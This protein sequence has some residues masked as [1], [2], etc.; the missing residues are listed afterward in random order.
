MKSFIE[1]GPNFALE[2]EEMKRKYNIAPGERVLLVSPGSAVM[3]KEYRPEQLRIVI[4]QLCKQHPDVHILLLDDINPD[5][6]A[7]YGRMADEIKSA[8]YSITRAEEGL[9]KM[10]T[11]MSLADLVIT[12]DTGLGHFAGAIGKPHIMLILGDPV[13]WSDAN[14]I[15]VNH[16][17]AYESY[18]TGKGTYGPAWDQPNEYYTEDRGK[19][20]GASDIDP[21]L[22]VQAANKVLGPK[23]A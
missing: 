11:L 7:R 5:K 18:R 15:R 6:K 17:V 14:T 16:S 4:E 2:A 12:P 19:I 23:A 1:T 13:Q 10:N 3:P 8:G 9:D 22:V 20:V 21:S